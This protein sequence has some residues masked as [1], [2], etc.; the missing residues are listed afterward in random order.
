MYR[1]ENERLS[2]IIMGQAVIELLDEKAPITNA[3]LLLK[4]QTYLLATEEAWRDAAIRGAI[5]IAQA[6]ILDNGSR[7][8]A[9]TSSPH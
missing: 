7:T 8:G 5:K 3:Q 1:N 2:D 6:A 9:Q 4:L